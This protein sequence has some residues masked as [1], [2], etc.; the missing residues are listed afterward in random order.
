MSWKEILK[1]D[2]DLWFVTGFDNGSIEVSDDFDRVSNTL[3]VS[4]KNTPPEQIERE[5]KK[6]ILKM[7]DASKK[8][9]NWNHLSEL[10]VD[11]NNLRIS[12]TIGWMGETIDEEMTIKEWLAELNR[13]DELE[14]KK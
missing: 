4:W 12:Y 7:V 3:N 1:S 5:V 10:N 11:R 14:Q 2:L 8:D 9:P 6:L 13:L